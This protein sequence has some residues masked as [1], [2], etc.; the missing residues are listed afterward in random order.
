MSS[1]SKG[2]PFGAET[3][4]EIE[5]SHDIEIHYKFQVLN[6]ESNHKDEEMAT[7]VESGV[8]GD[9][10]ETRVIPEVCPSGRDDMELQAILRSLGLL[11]KTT[12]LIFFLSTKKKEFSKSLM[13]I[14]AAIPR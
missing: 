3:V 11:V 6:D 13:D 14:F 4:P 7:I 9:V 2:E 10:S 8:G 5:Y 12:F 1:E